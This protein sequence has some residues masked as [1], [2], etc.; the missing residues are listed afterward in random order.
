M[1]SI[2]DLAKEKFKKVLEN[3]VDNDEQVI[4]IKIATTGDSR[5][6]IL[7]DKEK[8]GDEVLLEQNGSNI[9]VAN[10]KIA[11]M[12]DGR[13]VDYQISPQGEKFI[14]SNPIER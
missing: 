10:S 11:E 7:L 8:K 13:I 1:L 4:R 3:T 6:K 2:T 5:F 9:L 12:L 14:I